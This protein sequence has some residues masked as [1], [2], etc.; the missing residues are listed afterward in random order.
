MARL[1]V[2]QRLE[3]I[4]ALRIAENLGHGYTCFREEVQRGS[5]LVSGLFSC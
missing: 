2:V 1:L 5:Q 3:L 4:E